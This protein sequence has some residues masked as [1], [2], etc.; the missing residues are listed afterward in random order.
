MS[1]SDN[2]MLLNSR[3]LNWDPDKLR[4]SL[5]IHLRWDEILS[6][7]GLLNVLLSLCQ[8]YHNLHELAQLGFH[9]INI[10]S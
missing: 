7:S 2:E 1:F 6:D 5:T 9:Q 10:F 4:L 3:G 8:I